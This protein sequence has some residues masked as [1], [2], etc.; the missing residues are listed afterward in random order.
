MSLEFLEEVTEY[1]SLK[2]EQKPMVATH[3][4]YPDIALDKYSVTHSDQDAE[5]FTRLIEPKNKFALADGPANPDALANYTF[6]KK[7]LFLLK[8]PLLSGIKATSK[9]PLHW[10]IFQRTFS[11]DFIMD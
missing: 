10:R 11:L 3:L 8:L 1:L 2:F 5:P 6:C 9:L 7:S 4:D